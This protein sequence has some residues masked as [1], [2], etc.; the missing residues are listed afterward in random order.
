MKS[1]QIVPLLT[2]LTTS[3]NR[4]LSKS[5]R[6]CN[7]PSARRVRGSSLRTRSRSLR[8]TNSTLCSK[9]TII[10]KIPS[11]P[12]Q[13]PWKSLGIQASSTRRLSRD[14]TQ[15]GPRW[16]ALPMA[17]WKTTIRVRKHSAKMKKRMAFETRRL[18]QTSILS[19][20]TRMGRMVASR[21][22][23]KDPRQSKRAKESASPKGSGRNGGRMGT[24]GT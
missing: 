24:A 1:V 2:R 6:T 19:P 7:R 21:Q 4:L 12:R 17:W 11:R 5:N 15:P 8:P 14:K 10:S 3:P 23:L 20:L 13:R 16:E 18:T 22:L 9:E